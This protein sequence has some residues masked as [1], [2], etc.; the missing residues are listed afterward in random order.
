MNL[1][2][3]DT[4]QQKKNGIIEQKWHKPNTHDGDEDK[5]YSIFCGLRDDFAAL[6]SS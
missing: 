5:I 6:K 4:D 1:A 2:F 3:S